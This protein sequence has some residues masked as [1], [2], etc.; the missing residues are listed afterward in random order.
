MQLVDFSCVHW[1]DLLRRD[2]ERGRFVVSLWQH[3]FQSGLSKCRDD[4]GSFFRDA[5]G[6]YVGVVFRGHLGIDPEG[7]LGLSGRLLQLAGFRE[8]YG[9]V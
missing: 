7:L 5:Q 6:T 3:L 1:P 2:A 4:P 9:E 8:G